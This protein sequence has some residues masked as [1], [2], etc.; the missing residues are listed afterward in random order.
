MIAN[1]LHKV[2]KYGQLLIIKILSNVFIHSSFETP[3]VGACTFLLYYYIIRM[4]R[5]NIIEWFI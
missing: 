1:S 2:L 3:P 4:S 5:P